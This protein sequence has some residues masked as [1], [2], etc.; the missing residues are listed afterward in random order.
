MSASIALESP[1]EK[2]VES[3]STLGAAWRLFFR[4]PSGI[5]LGAQAILG[6][7][8][9]IWIGGWSAW[10]LLPVLGLIAFWPLQEWLIHVFILHFQPKK[11]GRHTFDL[12][13]AQKHRRHHREPWRIELLFMPTR[14]LPFSAPILALLWF[15]LASAPIAATGFA[16]YFWLAFHYEWVH[17]LVH[18]RYKPK[19]RYYQRLW[20]S[21]RLHHFMN[22]HYWYGVSML[23]AD[24]WLK[25]GPKKEA[26]ELSPTCR[27]LGRDSD[28]GEA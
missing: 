3:P 8:L 6:T 12:Y 28:L 13:T 11:I 22:E 2:F 26:V 17:Y 5:V 20:R 7:V 14:V 19:S 15:G 9:K 21:H 24:R 1:T 16:A 18:T 10:D 25:T 27:T 4:F 23:A